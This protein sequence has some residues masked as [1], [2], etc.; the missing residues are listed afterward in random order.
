[1]KTETKAELKKFIIGCAKILSFFLVLAILLEVLSITYFSKKGAVDYKTGLNKAYAYMQ[2]PNNTIDVLCIGNS[3]LYSAVVPA[4]FW[5]KFGFTSTVIASPHQTPLQ[6]YAML[7]EFYK[8]QKPKVV[9]IELDMLYDK[10]LKDVTG[11]ERNQSLASYVIDNY[12][13]EDFD[14][15]VKSHFSVFTFHNKWKKIGKKKRRETPNSHGY[16][17]SEA[18]CDVNIGEYMIE[19]D[20]KEPIK[21]NSKDYIKKMIQFVESNGGSVFFAEMP[22]VTSWN[23]ERHNAAAEFCEEIDRDFL[24]YNLMIDELG[25]DINKSFRDKGNHLNYYAACAISRHMG[26]YILANYDMEDRRNDPDYEFYDKSIKKF[27][28]EVKVARKREKNK[29]LKK[30]LDEEYKE[31][32]QL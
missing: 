18:V 16:K 26:K 21:Q 25:V 22:T 30:Q 17:Y 14:E 29:F 28:K 3:D 9:V 8:T 19:T 27:Y 31:E 6:S 32:E 24:D 2:E 11:I 13:A 20:E 1:M 7:K 12:D 5:T 15:V 10:S 4:E 23:M